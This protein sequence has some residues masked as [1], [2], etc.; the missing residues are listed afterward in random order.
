MFALQR[1]RRAIVI[2]AENLESTDPASARLL[3]SGLDRSVAGLLAIEDS[4]FRSI[5]R[6]PSLEPLIAQAVAES[7]YVRGL[8]ERLEATEFSHSDWPGIVG[9]LLEAVEIHIDR[10]ERSVLPSAF[11][12]MNAGDAAEL[13]RLLGPPEAFR[14]QTNSS[15]A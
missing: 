15:A 12:L 9:D 13:G 8:L 3:V 7:F 14:T 1:I 2:E 5:R 6:Y 11:E 10:L 4:A